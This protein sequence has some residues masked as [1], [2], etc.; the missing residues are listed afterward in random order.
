MQKLAIFAS[1]NGSSLDAI[2]EACQ[3][4]KL[5]FEISLVISNNTDAKVLKSAKDKSIT[6]QVVNAKLYDDV[7]LKIEEL[8]D[9]YGCK[10]IFLA[11]YMKKI[12]VSLTKKYKIL[13]SHPALLPKFG[14]KGMYGRFVHDAVIASGDKVSGVTIHEVNENYDEG[15]IVLQKSMELSADET[16][17]S[18]EIKIKKLE[19]TAIV[20]A[21]QKYV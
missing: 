19:K 7:D 21:L 20:E 13:N 15:A 10:Y 3:N 17:E 11:G 4:K 5:D 9:E 8:L 18:L 1:H 12:P 14:G 6:A 16:S 2:Y